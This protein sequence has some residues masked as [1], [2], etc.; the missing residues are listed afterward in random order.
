MLYARLLRPPAHGAA[1]K[2]V[3]VSEAEKIPG[4][5][6]VNQDGLVAALSLDPQMAQNAVPKIK[7]VFD[8]FPR[9]EHYIKN[10]R[11]ETC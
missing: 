9:T 11:R 8:Q 4:V 10:A 2:S 7:A 1:L 3:D 5:S 6:I